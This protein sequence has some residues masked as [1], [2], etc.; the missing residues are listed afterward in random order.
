MSTAACCGTAPAAVDFVLSLQNALTR[1]AA[2]I[3][4]MN[5]RASGGAR[6]GLSSR[7]LRQSRRWASPRGGRVTLNLKRHP[8]R[9][10]MAL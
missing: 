8:D 5:S 6:P 7:T 1:E 3:I 10:G 4:L 2:A 9:L